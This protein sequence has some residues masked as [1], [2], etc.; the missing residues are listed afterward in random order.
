MM[1]LYRVATKVAMYKAARTLAR[2][3][4]I[5]RLPRM[6]PL[7]RLNGARPTKAAMFRRSRLPSSERSAMSVIDATRPIPSTPWSRLSLGRQRGLSL[8]ESLNCWSVSASSCVS[9]HM[10]VRTR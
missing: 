9:Q 10:C 1:E 7:S 8:T 2:P 5:L 6:S 4:H 3:P